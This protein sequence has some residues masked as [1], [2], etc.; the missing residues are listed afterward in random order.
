MMKNNTPGRRHIGV[1]WDK[2]LNK[3]RVQIKA[4][5]KNKYVRLYDDFDVAIEAGKERA[6]DEFGEFANV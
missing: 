3:W 6:L 2:K 4:N 5:G 1:S